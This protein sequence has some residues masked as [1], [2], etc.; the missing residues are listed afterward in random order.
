M[1]DGGIISFIPGNANSFYEVHTFLAPAGGKQTTTTQEQI[2][3]TLTFTTKPVSNKVEVLVVA[4]G[5][6]G[7]KGT[8]AYVPA[9]GGAG[10]YI[11][12]DAY[13]IGGDA[14]AFAVKVGLG[15]EAPTETGYGNK[16]AG[17]IGATRGSN[18]GNSQFGADDS[19]KRIEAYGGGGGSSHAAATATSGADGGSGGG[20]VYNPNEGGDAY[21][22]VAP[23]G[24]TLA[25]YKGGGHYKGAGGGAGGAGGAA[26]GANN[27]TSALGGIG[28]SSDISGET[29]WY[30]GG[31]AAGNVATNPEAYGAN[32]DENGA[33]GTG[34]GGGSNGAGGSGI[35]I[36]RFLHSEAE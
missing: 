12:H 1:A 10:G 4:G 35:V 24:A 6:G 32:G 8:T 17:T 16:A 15:G 23:E 28:V 36:V 13:D 29:R 2:A 34:D 19:D 5:G 11:Y 33:P 18:G 22:G 25:G 7:G 30:A 21:P 14:S 3:G 9:G 31:G 20:G 26:T 27:T